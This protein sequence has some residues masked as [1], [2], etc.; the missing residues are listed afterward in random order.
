MSE[1]FNKIPIDIEGLQI[2]NIGDLQLESEHTLKDVQ[3]GYHT[4]GQLNTKKD[5]VIWVCHALTANSNVSDWWSGL[6]GAGKV[7][8]PSK[9][10]IVCANILGSPYG[11]T[12]ARS[13][14][15]N[16]GQPYGLEMPLITIKAQV[17]AHAHIAQHLGIG[18]I[19]YAIGGSCGGHQVL[20][21]CLHSELHVNNA[22]LLVTSARETPWSI[23][24]HE[25]QRMALK[26]DV[27]FENNSND[28]GKNGLKAARGM[29]MIAYRTIKQYNNQQEEKDDRWDDFKAASYIQ[30]Q[31]KKLAD[32][33][34]AHCY[35]HLIKTLD[36][37]NV[38]RGRGG[39][40]AAL[41]TMTTNCLIISVDSDLLIPVQEQTFL[42]QFIPANKHVVIES[43]YGH[44][45]F[46]I[47]FDKINTI[48]K[49]AFAI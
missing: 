13:T 10:F 49:Q 14:D 32:R 40:K 42:A 34:Y 11:S 16:S 21:M 19:Q 43:N 30:Y 46:L 38:G 1:N 2:L 24:I 48:I 36:T 6:F 39:V 44:D 45:G 12:N 3:V 26:A 20:E 5:N 25:A 17:T 23:A 27:T 33:F 28:A 4:F 18:A 9:Y 41:K 7:L 8:D 37:H 29:S 15:P 47:E 31:G 35:Y 22:I